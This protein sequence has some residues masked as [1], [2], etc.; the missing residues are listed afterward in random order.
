MNRRFSRAVV[1]G[2]AGFVGSHIVDKLV[3]EGLAVTVIDDFSSGKLSNI[4]RNVSSS[5]VKLVRGDINDKELI[6]KALKDIEV[7]FHEAAI[8]SVQRSI[9][10]PELTNHVNVD[11]TRSMLEACVDS[12]ISK[13]VLAS[14]AAIYGDPKHLPCG[15]GT[16]ASP[17]SPYASSKLTD[18]MLCEQ[19]SHGTGLSTIALR[20]FNI[21]GERS[22]SSVYTGVIN[23]FAERLIKGQ[24]PVIYGDGSQTRDFINVKDI[25]A[26]NFL[27]SEGN[28]RRFSVFN[29]GTGRQV[30]V[31][32]LARLESSILLGRCDTGI[33]YRQSLVGDV[34]HSYA[35]VSHIR[36]TFG[37]EPIIEFEKGLRD[38]LSSLYATVPITTN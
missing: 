12:R 3:S 13:F 11:G 8:V 19:V 5:K 37:F 38:Y 31:L 2:G 1:T 6:R 22:A 33:D 24:H 28:T 18:E 15:E 30:T 25:A 17:M 35:D 7:V 10:E 32:D 20:Y 27:A 29:V 34:K 9:V 16:P 26:A 21:Y 23:A 4:E 36:K 14:S